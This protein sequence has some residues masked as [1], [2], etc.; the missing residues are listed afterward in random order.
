MNDDEA[1]PL[2]E[3]TTTTTSPTST[4]QRWLKLIV[5]TLAVVGILFAIS[6]VHSTT[7]HDN[8]LLISKHHLSLVHKMAIATGTILP[9]TAGYT[10]YTKLSDAD[11][12]TLFT[13]FKEMYGRSYKT[14]KEESAR[15]LNFVSSMAKI[16]ERNAKV[17]SVGGTAIHGVGKPV[18]NHRHNTTN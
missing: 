14:E 1:M 3:T 17:M 5:A 2:V 6:I 9:M 18:M 16:D 12:E 4:S 7:G 15:Y 8:D 11:L 13:Q 10:S